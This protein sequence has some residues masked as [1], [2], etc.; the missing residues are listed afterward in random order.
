MAPNNLPVGVYRTLVAEANRGL[1]VLHR[2]FEIRR[3]M[4]GL[5]DLAYYDI[6]P[7]ATKLAR[8]FDL[9]EIRR[10]VLEAVRPLGQDYVDTLAKAT[11]GRWM[12]PYPRRG[13]SAGAY[14]NPSAYA[15]H[16]YLL[17]NLHDD[18]GSVS[19]YAHEW[20]HA[21]HSLMAN[22]AQPFETSNYPTFTAEIASTCNEQLLADYML[23]QAKTR[24]EKLFY[25]DR[26]C[27][28]LRGTFYRQTLF[29]EFELAIHETAERGE[30]LS[31]K[32]MTAIYLELLKKYHGAG[33]TIDPAYGIEWAFPQHFYYDFYVFQYATS[34]AASVYFA[35]KILAGKTAD[36]DAYLGVLKA[37]GSGYPVD[38]LKRAGLD[39]TTPAPYQALVAKLARTLDQM[40]ALLDK[41]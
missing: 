10:L 38:L 2:Y 11:S 26:I 7:P 37:G 23:R 4:L 21:M 15:V 27:E 12:D 29:A 8:R 25:L 6:Y 9:T 18:Y 22:K 13:K 3:R 19:T 20:G 32:R 31:G 1:P 16:P 14:M 17:L 39:M 28:L 36:R 33:M 34:I 40:E 5:P 30:A 24:E 35:D 41:A